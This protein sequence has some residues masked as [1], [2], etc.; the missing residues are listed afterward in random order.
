MAVSSS[1]HVQATPA[2][3]WNV[4]GDPSRLGEWV[5][6]HAGFVGE[7]PTSYVAGAEYVER[8]RVMG[9][10]NDVSWTVSEVSDGSQ[11]VLE[12]RGPMGIGIL[13]DYSVQADGDGS[14]ISISQN[15][16][17][18]AVFAVK[19]QLEKE[20]KAAQEASLDKLKALLDG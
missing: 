15:F 2:A 19:A 9:M 8:L 5:S 14:A 12:G 11:I 7:A 16:S 20:V 18:G 3:T 17:G 13:G 10:P 6:N 4:L 1:V